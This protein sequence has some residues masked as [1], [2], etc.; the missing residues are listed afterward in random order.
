MTTEREALKL[1]LDALIW[2]FDFVDFIDFGLNLLILL[3]FY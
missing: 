1:A 3:I 2:T